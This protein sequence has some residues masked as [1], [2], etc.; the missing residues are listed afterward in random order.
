[1]NYS[2]Y[3]SL[4]YN[5]YY[6][7]IG[8]QA[9]VFS[10]IDK[11][12]GYDKYN[13]IKAIY[14][15]NA[16]MLAL[17]LAIIL[18]WI[19]KEF[20]IL[21]FIIGLLF[22][23]FNQWLIV[24]GR[25]L[26]W[27]V[28]IMYLPF[29]SMLF[30]F[31]YIEY[32]DKKANIIILSIISFITIFIKSTCGYE[33][34][35]T[36]LICVTLPFIYYSLKNRI[37]L[38]QFA[39]KFILISFFGILGFCCCLV[40]HGFLKSQANGG[41]KEFIDFMLFTAGKR[42]GYGAGNLNNLDFEFTNSLD[43]SVFKVFELYLKKERPLLGDYKM[44]NILNMFIVSVLISFTGDNSL[45]KDYDAKKN[46]NYIILI[47]LSLLAPF[48]WFI[49]AKGHSYVHIH[50]SYFLWSL[51]CILIIGGY[52][53]YV[54][55]GIFRKLLLKVKDCTL[56]VKCIIVALSILFVVFW[57][58]CEYNDYYKVN[59]EIKESKLL[60]D[61]GNYAIYINDNILYLK[62]KK[63]YISEDEFFMR[64]FPTHESDLEDLLSNNY[65]F[66]MNYCYKKSEKIP[67][68]G[69]KV[70]S[71]QLPEYSISYIEIGQSN[72]EVRLWVSNMKLE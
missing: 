21:A 17:M 66:E 67:F 48:S 42:T 34:L 5:P 45:N 37:S 9:M 53:G 7:Q 41:I 71:I 18:Y 28:W 46:R 36:C 25:N 24:I 23:F 49:L 35:S 69:K 12:L 64:I 26:Y 16:F 50:I 56:W 52:L 68:W 61:N 4:K 38:K 47:V 57:N 54:W 40:V 30:Y 20:G 58:Q 32:K 65:D 14:I 55:Q 2:Q 6:Q 1:M 44:M 19:K 63:W 51:P 22:A 29:V 70:T 27:V 13:N 62:N 60:E 3:E 59:S 43:A 8:A 31:M 39:K 11:V 72:D 33:Y 15:I 10:L